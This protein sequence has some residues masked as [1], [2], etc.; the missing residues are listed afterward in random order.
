MAETSPESLTQQPPP[1]PPPPPPSQYW[2]YHCD[3]RV[4]V[5]TLTN[6]ADL[7]CCECNN[8]FV[9]SITAA[10]LPP[11]L[12]P[13]PP[14]NRR[15]QETSSSQQYLRIL[16]L[17]AQAAR[18]EDVPP[19]QPTDSA[20][21]PLP[22]SED[23]DFFRIEVDGWDNDEFDDED[24]LVFSNTHADIS[25]NDEIGEAE[26]DRDQEEN[27]V[28]RRRRRRDILMRSIRDF[29]SRATSGQNRLWSNILMGLEDNSIELQLE[30]PESDGY[31]GNPED[32]VDAAGY[33][34]L[35][36]N[37]AENDGGVRRGAPPAARSAVSALKT[38]EITP[39]EE[40]L[41]CT[42]C[43]EFVPVGETA[44][45]LPCGHGYHG[46]CIVPWLGSRNSCPVCRFEL[47]TDD[48]E[49]EEERKKRSTTTFVVEPSGS[50]SNY[51]ESG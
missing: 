1:P 15:I 16:R 26:N 34:V 35:L 2:C 30:M 18:D 8:G 17:I 50:G 44:T 46:D 28:D 31:I 42:V 51:T 3:K 22:P 40:G 19:V 29:A 45:K 37:L 36:Q 38:L 9:E 12:P 32:Y 10:S 43:K 4:S 49:Y 41:V 48:P 11:S 27:E 39:E 33:E 14:T 47:P 7:I 23:D 21:D 20:S 6:I 24:E 13:T 25:D 5:E